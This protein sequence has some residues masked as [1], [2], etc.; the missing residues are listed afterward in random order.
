MN[1]PPY[2]R[3]WQDQP[4]NKEKRSLLPRIIAAI[5]LNQTSRYVGLLLGFLFTRFKLRLPVFGGLC[6]FD[7]GPL[8]GLCYTIFFKCRFFFDCIEDVL[9]MDMGWVD[10]KY[11]FFVL[12]CSVPSPPKRHCQAY[13]MLNGSGMIGSGAGRRSLKWLNN[14]GNVL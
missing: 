10:R 7:D 3:L 8:V 14:D 13:P 5:N 6:L 1:F 2:L 9:G 12:E 4:R 11:A